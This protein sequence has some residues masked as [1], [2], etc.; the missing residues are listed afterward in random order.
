MHPKI[1]TSIFARMTALAEQCGAL[2]LAQGLMWLEP[3][4]I[5]LE[6][7]RENIINPSLQQYSAPAGL[8]ALRRT[9][10]LLSEYYFSTSYDPESEITITTGATEGL[11]A[12]VVALTRPGNKVVFL[13]PAYDSYLPA[14]Q[15]AGAFPVP[16][17]LEL[18]SQGVRIPWEAIVQS[19]DTHTDLLI[20]NFPHNP[21][22]R[23]LKAEDIEWIER[24]SLLHPHLHFVMDEAYELMT[25][26][27]DP[28]KAESVP[29]LS[30]RQSSLLRSKA[31]I[32]GSLGKMVG[33]TGWRIGYVLA[34]PS[35]TQKIRSVHQFVTY[36]AG[37]P[38][39]EVIARYLGEAPE[40]AK[41]FHQA[42]LERRQL[43]IRLLVEHTSLEV[44]PPEGSYFVL[45]RPPIKEKD[46][47]LAERLTR[48]VGVATIPLS[49]FYHNGHDP[50][51]LRLCF[52]RPIEMIEEAVVRLKRVFPVGLPISHLP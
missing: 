46:E 39:Q 23:Q 31:V 49:P 37:M 26:H 45:V 10:A 48:E 52:A 12:A 8:P 4:P 13:E 14:I 34:A 24:I 43:L 41:Y 25:W 3:D 5:L 33:A 30:I 15:M 38:L 2:N 21:T 17:S 47:L 51:W 36:C 9:V 32:V 35:L 19:I 16:F 11:F 44:L 27:T 28:Y 40:R 20:L 42:L 29:P 7:A 1:G 22:G 6:Y 18:H 50:G